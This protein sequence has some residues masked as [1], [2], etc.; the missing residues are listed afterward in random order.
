MVRS[1]KIPRGIRPSWRVL[2]PQRVPIRRFSIPVPRGKFV[3]ATNKENA[4]DSD[5]SLSQQMNGL[6]AGVIHGFTAV[7]SRKNPEDC[8]L[9]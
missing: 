1:R 8:A 6:G 9:Q 4:T 2:I 5:G 7:S 3:D